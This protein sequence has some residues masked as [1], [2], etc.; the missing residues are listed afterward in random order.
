MVS[1]PDPKYLSKTNSFVPL[2]PILLF[3]RSQMKVSCFTFV[4]VREVSVE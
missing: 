3:N 4:Y 2:K 1:S